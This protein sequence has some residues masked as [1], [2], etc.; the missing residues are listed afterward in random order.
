M[1]SIRWEAPDLTV[2]L[3]ILGDI[4]LWR[5]E[6]RDQMQHRVVLHVGDQ[7]PVQAVRPTNPIEPPGN[8]QGLGQGRAHARPSL[9]FG[10]AGSEEHDL[11]VHLLR[12]QHQDRPRFIVPGQV[13]EVAS[14]T[15][16]GIG[17]A[18]AGVEHCG[19]LAQG[20]EEHLATGLVD[21]HLEG[22]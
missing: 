18:A 17:V 14:C 16:A 7:H 19:S 3:H 4:G 9:G 20:I 13:P 1:C 10:V 8:L 6:T 15:V 22:G 5:D 21:A 12:S 2:E 11:P